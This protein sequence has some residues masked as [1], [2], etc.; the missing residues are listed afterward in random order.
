VLKPLFS[1][2][3]TFALL[4]DGV[5]TFANSVVSQAVAS[6]A[7][8]SRQLFIKKRVLNDRAVALL[9]DYTA[10][11][12]AALIRRTCEVLLAERWQRGDRLAVH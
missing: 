4:A 5:S 6:V 8:F 2:Q 11:D 3:E 1:D 9:P 12:P 10:P 7:P